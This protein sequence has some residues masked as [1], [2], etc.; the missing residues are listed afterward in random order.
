MRGIRHAFFVFYQEH[1]EINCCLPC[2]PERAKRVEGS[3]PRSRRI[4][5]LRLRGPLGRSAQN[6]IFG[7]ITSLNN[8]LRHR[9]LFHVLTEEV[10]LV[11][12]ALS[13]QG[14]LAVDVEHMADLFSR[15]FAVDM[16]LGFHT[17]A[18]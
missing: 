4:R 12:V 15:L 1:T 14:Q 11:I 8:N 10:A 5:I 18:P 13:R 9:F 6:D 3:V 7:S 16:Q 2:H 17:L